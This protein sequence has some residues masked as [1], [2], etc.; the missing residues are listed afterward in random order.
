M[1]VGSF[2]KGCQVVVI[3]SGPGGYLADIRLAQLKK[4]VIL[5]EAEPS[6]G[7]ICLNEGCIPSK[8]LIHA[9]DFYTDTRTSGTFGINVEKVSLDLPKVISWKDGVVQRLTGGV[10]TLCTKN[11]AEVMRG[12]ARFIS[13]RQVEV[14]GPDGVQVVQFE[15]AVIATG[16]VPFDLPGFLRDGETIIG[17]K[18][19]LDLKE[20]PGKLVVIGGGYIGLELGSV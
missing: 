9:A 5:V 2:A 16:S 15:Q 10:K 17:S 11:G 12:R 13:D 18:E 4:D 19:A 3:G 1:V 6:L 7:G 14:A 20:V 8:A